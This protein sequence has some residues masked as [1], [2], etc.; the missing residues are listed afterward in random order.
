MS[1]Q[2]RETCDTAVTGRGVASGPEFQNRTC[3]CDTHDHD[4]TVQPLPMSHP[5]IAHQ[6]TSTT[7]TTAA[8][9]TSM[10][11]QQHWWAS[12][13][14]TSDNNLNNNDDDGC[15]MS[16]MYSIFSFLFFLYTNNYLLTI[17]LQY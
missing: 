8:T 3:T 2:H 4:T 5:M 15:L 7:T 13:A 16:Q 6:L 9:A 1:P 10:H 17:R 12:M 11:Q 14:S